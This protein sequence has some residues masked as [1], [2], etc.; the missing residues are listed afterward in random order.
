MTFQMLLKKTRP[1]CACALA[2]LLLA[3]APCQAFLITAVAAPDLKRP[4][5]GVLYPFAINVRGTYTAGDLV[6]AGVTDTMTVTAEYWDEDVF[7][8]DPIHLNAALVIPL[9]GV[10]QGGAWGPVPITFQV[11]CSASAV[12]FGPAGSTGENPMNDG[13]FRFTTGSGLTWT[14]HGS[15]GYNTVSCAST[16]D[17]SNPP[18][19]AYKTEHQLPEPEGLSMLCAGLAGLALSSRKKLSARAS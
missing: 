4:T 16:A 14:N 13:Y 17:G 10:V 1:S 11:G 6:F 9:Q 15:W 7:F 18:Q 2:T 8:D 19:S 3:A 5:D 12:V